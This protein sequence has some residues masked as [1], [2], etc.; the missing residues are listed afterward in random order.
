MRLHRGINF[1]RLK[2]KWWLCAFLGAKR[3]AKA[4]SEFIILSRAKRVECARIVSSFGRHVG[5]QE[6]TLQHGGQYKSYYFVEKSNAIQYLPKMRLLS[7]LG[8][9]IIFM[10]SVNFRHQQD[11]SY[12]G[13]QRFLSCAAGI[14]GNRLV[15]IKT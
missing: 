7:N 6:Y 8:C 15:T 3:G 10:C 13:Y 5:G 9:K 11:S 12:P 1:A 4:R 14:F 2:L